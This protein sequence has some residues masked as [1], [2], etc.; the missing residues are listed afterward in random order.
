MKEVYITVPRNYLLWNPWP[1][2]A[3]YGN[4][5]MAIIWGIP[6]VEFICN[7]HPLG[8]L[9]KITITDEDLMVMRLKSPVGTIVTD[10]DART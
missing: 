4:E 9:Y 10:I 6:E 2:G 1:K 3:K 5:A 7:N 8:D